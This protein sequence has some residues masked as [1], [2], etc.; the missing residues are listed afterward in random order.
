MV[1]VETDVVGATDP[2]FFLFF[3]TRALGARSHSMGEERERK[4]VE[5]LCI[6]IRRPHPTTTRKWPTLH[7]NDRC[8]TDG[9]FSYCC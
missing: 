2:F 5:D 8:L 7:N 4:C 3:S 1:L 6:D 9:Y